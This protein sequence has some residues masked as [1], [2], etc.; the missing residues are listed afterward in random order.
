[1]K[2]K[3]IDGV[4]LTQISQGYYLVSA[5]SLHGKVPYVS[6]INDVTALCWNE[7]IKGA[8]IDQLVT[9]VQEEYDVPDEIQLR[10]DI[11]GLLTSLEEK[12]YIYHINE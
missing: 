3:T 10:N 7:L 6:S 5:R 8:D 1:M 2:Y 9:C 12:G 4:V 11:E